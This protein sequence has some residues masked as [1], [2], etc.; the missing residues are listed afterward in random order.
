MTEDINRHLDD[1]VADINKV[2]KAV[3]NDER[4]PQISEEIVKCRLSDISN[5]L[6]DLYNDIIGI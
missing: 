5:A 4:P 3:N 2:R 1:L 6:D